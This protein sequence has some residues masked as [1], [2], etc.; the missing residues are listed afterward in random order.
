VDDELDEARAAELTPGLHDVDFDHLLREVL[1]RVHGVLD[2][3]ERLRLLLDAVVTMA[4]DL[5]LDGVLARI[6]DIASRLVDANYAAL[7]VLD[8]G[9]ERRLRTFVHHGMTPTQVSEIGD[10]PTGHGLLGL[11]IDEPRPIR[12]HDIAAHPA[13][14]GFPPHHPPMKS[15]LGVPV[16][17]RD[18]VFGNLYLT[19]KKGPGD[20]TKEDEDVVV[21]LAAAAGVAIENAR[22]YEEAASR[23]RWLSA[24]ADITA[25][26]ADTSADDNA[27]QAVADRAR[28]VAQADVSWVV[29]G[30]DADSLTLE[31][32]SGLEAD[33]EELRTL[34]LDRSLASI[35]VGSGEPIS[36]PDL[37]DDPRA[38][39]PT[40]ALGWPRL[41]PALLVPLS[42][43][44]RVEGALALAWF[45]EHAPL[46]DAVD[47]GMPASFAEQAALAIQVAR[48][49]ADQQR[50]AVFEDRD[51]IG[52]DLH[53]LVIQRLFAVGLSLQGAGRRLVDPEV[54]ARLTQAV[55][56]LDDT[57]KDIRRTIFALGSLGDSADIQAEVTRL[58]DRAA[59]TLKFRPKLRFDGPVRSLVPTDVAPDILAVLRE[60]LSNASRH[61]EATSVDVLLAAGEE[62]SLVVADD[63]RGIGENAT[64]GGLGN[65]R[66]RAMKHGGTLTVSTAPGRGTTI[67]WS[68]PL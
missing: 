65:M 8:V 18:R 15:F 3:Q 55:D 16:R 21:A 47:P 53:D 38:L 24:T 9:H 29:T 4:A 63:G 11:L 60:A 67:T 14:Y 34:P 37:A 33:P 26:L 10:L 32:V 17:I 20:F 46:F 40:S 64:E 45:P 50:L 58:V 19:E 2:E 68:V 7:G 52:R 42:S 44:A 6:V 12:L 28:E 48:A 27:L 54:A 51:R 31:V 22:L 13:S 25:L 23:Q 49:R 41:G 5:T 36:V 35:V 56:D 39:D 61:A 1:N 43:G 62:V 66:E 57:I 59:E 30:L